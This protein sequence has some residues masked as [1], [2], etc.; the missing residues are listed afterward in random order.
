MKI[1]D[2]FLAL[3]VAFVW[4]T[5]FVLIE[6]GLRDFPPFLFASLRFLLVAFPLVFLLPRPKVSLARP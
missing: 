2:Q 5:N 4:G 3:L 6:I 1:T